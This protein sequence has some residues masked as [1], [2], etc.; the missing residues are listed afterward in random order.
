[1]SEVKNQVIALRDGFYALVNGRLFG[2]WRMREYALAG[3]QVEQ[4]RR[5]PKPNEPGA[6]EP[7]ADDPKS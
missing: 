2:P 1:M 6:S 4:R 7:D 5:Q 3:L